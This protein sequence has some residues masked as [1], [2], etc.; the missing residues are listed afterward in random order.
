MTDNPWKTISSETIFENP[1]IKLV[2]DEVITPSGKPGTY[3]VLEAKP[4]VI[5]VALQDDKVLMINQHRYPINKMTIEFP[6]G[7]IE[8]GESPLEAAKRE[9]AEETGYEASDWVNVGQFYE[10]VSI[11]RQPGYLFI[12][13]DLKRT[14]QHKMPE[15]GISGS[16]FVSMKDLE[17]MI[18]HGDIIDALTPA[19]LFKT[20]LFLRQK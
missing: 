20:Q 18:A 12:A 16:T 10:L 19:V 13:R 11:S 15:D 8:D 2:K 6:A 17:S 5:V 1:W 9:L 14:N 4:F 7:G 3:T